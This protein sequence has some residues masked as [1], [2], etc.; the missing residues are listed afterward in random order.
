MVYLSQKLE[1]PRFV[2]KKFS[3]K[4]DTVQGE[5]AKRIPQHLRARAE[6]AEVVPNAKNN[7]EVIY[8]YGPPKYVMEE[9]EEF[10]KFIHI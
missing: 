5:K 6:E 8:V 2:Q 7:C 10:K 4:R 9:A 1:Y 3:W